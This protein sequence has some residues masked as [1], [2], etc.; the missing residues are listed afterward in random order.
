MHKEFTTIT[1]LTTTN[2]IPLNNYTAGPEEKLSHKDPV[3]KKLK[4]KLSD[5]CF[6]AESGQSKGSRS[7]SKPGFRASGA[8]QQLQVP[9]P[10]GATAPQVKARLPPAVLS[11]R[12]RSSRVS[13][14]RSPQPACA[15]PRLRQRQGGSSQCDPPS[16][17]SASAGE[18]WRQRYCAEKEPS[19][20][21]DRGKK[22]KQK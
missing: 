1:K 8:K 9:A 5:R 11:P 12:L 4:I 21:L 20:G 16:K 14:A 13:L 10:R 15:P 6:F 2:A 22:I 3:I 17:Q 7:T 18:I 19:A